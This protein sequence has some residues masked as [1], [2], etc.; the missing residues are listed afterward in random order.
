MAEGTIDAYNLGKNGVVVDKSLVHAE[1][2]ELSKAQNAIHDKHGSDGGIC[3]REGLLKNHTVAAAGSILGFIGAPLGPGPAVGT[4]DT[5]TYYL[6]NAAGS[7]HK[8]TNGMSTS[9]TTTV[10]AA[11]KASI[12]AATLNGRLYY[13]S[14]AE[15][16]RVF[17]GVQD[18]LFFTPPTF[19]PTLNGIYVADGT[20]YAGIR[21][22]TTSGYIVELDEDG[23]MTQIGAAFASN[24][25]PSLL[26]FHQND[27]F[28]LAVKAASQ[29]VVLRIRRD[30]ATSTT[31]WTVDYT[32]TGFTSVS[33]G[34]LASY[35]GLLYLGVQP[36]VGDTAI[37]YER[38][39]AAVYTA[40]DTATGA[41]S[42]VTGL[43]V[44]K[45]VLYAAFGH[46]SG[47]GTA[48]V[49]R[50]TTDGTTWST[51][52]T[53]GTE[54]D[55][56]AFN[57]A[58]NKLFVLVAGTTVAGYS[59]TNGTTWVAFAVTVT[60]AEE[61]FGVFAASGDGPSFG[62]TSSFIVLQGGTSLQI[63]NAAGTLVTLTMPT[64]ITLDAS[65][66]PRF[67]VFDR[68]IIM[69]NTPSR[70][71][72]I[73]AEGIVRVLS[74][75]PP[76]KMIELD[77]DGGAGALTG[78][79]KALQTFLIEDAAG[80]II[81]ES[82]F[83]PVME[84]A[85]T[86]SADTL[87][88]EALNISP[89]NITASQIYRTVT[90]GSTYFPWIRVDGNTLTQ[91]VSDDQT[92]AAIGLVAAPV[93]GTAP[94]LSLVATWRG[95]VWGVDRAD[96]DH[97]RYTEAG[98]MWSWPRDNDI[99][100]GRE[101]ADARGI[102]AIMA[103][104][105]ALGFGR[106]DSIN[107]VTGTQDNNFRSV[108]LTENCGVESQETVCIYKD[109]AYFLWKDGV[110]TWDSN[111]IKCISDTK[112][113][114]WFVTDTY[115]NRTRFPFAWACVDPVRN[116]YCLFLTAAG[117]SAENRWVEYDMDEG[118]WWGPHKTGAFTPI[119]A[120][121]SYTSADRA[122]RLVGSSSG[123]LW[124]DQST[125]TDDT[126]TA[127]DM[128]VDTKRHD[129]GTPKIDKVWRDMTL[130]LVPQTGG[131]LT[132]NPSVGELDATASSQSLQAELGEGSYTIGRL[133]IGKSAKLNFRHAVA[134][135]LVQILGY[136]IDFHEA[137]QR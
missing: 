91:S 16:V 108:V 14:T 137:G 90:A 121:V 86:A 62:A 84:T 117:D 35:R 42:D 61:A 133:G 25:L 33:A 24:Y 100:I 126:A 96:V 60:A 82:D 11:V 40:R 7:W 87:D 13:V 65:R 130:S 3:N 12:P 56:G 54:D 118:T 135:R 17:D 128:D 102:T 31:A 85:F 122:L 67:A 21:N 66:P 44:F 125:R 113:R 81:A 58:G 111:G 93:L 105:D 106:R 114:S 104:R 98:Q 4:E 27:L 80:N 107:Q 19:A 37:V 73:D 29:A 83:S 9:A 52:A 39:T 79:Y 131:L 26:I 70:P 36:A 115:F 72:T 47:A 101:G 76:T 123:F 63:L 97:A 116:K 22:S 109:V 77:D 48:N 50:K 127:I 119:S 103:R 5:K 120:G 75:L 49:I 64:G 129:G 78:T 51:A 30:A 46:Y 20:L 134:G 68:F 55:L 71:V 124:K 53:L 57:L 136:E 41:A 112:V 10:L 89:D 88:A 8:S 15:T 18:S 95:R 6:S 34:A 32:T 74:P 38:S 99:L 2:G 94:R 43:V 45:D 132:I 59:S 69:A 23:R 28:V 1:D 92:D 110:Y